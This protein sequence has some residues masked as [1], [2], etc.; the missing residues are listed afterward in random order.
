M[1]LNTYL[2][3]VYPP[4]K[5]L[6]ADHKIYLATDGKTELEGPG[7]VDKRHFLLTLFDPFDVVGLVKGRD[8]K[9]RFWEEDGVGGPVKSENV[10][11]REGG[12]PEAAVGKDLAAA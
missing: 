1:L 5:Y 9:N 3:N 12:R 11:R 4:A 8:A 10:E 2:M 7:A 6:P